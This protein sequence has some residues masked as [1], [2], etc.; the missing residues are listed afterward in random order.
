MI[1]D[2]YDDTTGAVLREILSEQAHNL[3][4]CVVKSAGLVPSDEFRKDKTLFAW[5]AQNRYAC[6]TPEDTWLSYHY[7]QKTAHMVPIQYHDLIMDSFAQ[8]AAI[9]DMDL[10]MGSKEAAVAMPA[11]SDS[12][13]LVVEKMDTNMASKAA[14][15]LGEDVFT[16]T[17]DNQW[18]LRLYPVHT[19][20]AME[21][22]VLWFPRQ[23]T[24]ELAGH[25]AKVAARLVELCQEHGINLTA[26]LEDEIRPIKRSHLLGHLQQ[27]VGII[28]D[29]NARAAR[30]MT[31]E[32]T[33]AYGQ[34]TASVRPIDGTIKLAYQELATLA[35]QD[36]LPKKFWAH[37]ER[38][39]KLAGF[40]AME[41]VTPVGSLSS[42]EL[43][44]DMH[45]TTCKLAG[46]IV[47]IP[48][49]MEKISSAIWA[50]LA[51]EVLE[52]M[53]NFTKVADVVE[54]LDE[55]KQQILLVQIRGF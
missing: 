30:D 12:D 27:R 1:Y 7:F 43:E 13:Y 31:L 49:M 48:Q 6:D 22:A 14:S 44:D 46:Q 55:Q 54:H 26:A 23:L 16:P 2:F 19:K 18:I 45:K 4:E 24:G 41:G 10:G 33:S 47:F 34:H 15:F 36:P 11:L 21:D 37:F 39:D 51:P 9:H 40:D 35:Y 20:Q 42:R 38:L 53:F 52:N 8:A 28:D 25:R 3:P 29:T 32:K 5:G 50:D 17:D